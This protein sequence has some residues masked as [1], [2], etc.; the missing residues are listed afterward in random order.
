MNEYLPLATL[1]R[2]L[3][4]LTLT[5]APHVGHLPPWVS[6]LIAGLIVWRGLTAYRQWRMPGTMVKIALALLAFVGVLVHFDGRLG[7]Q[8]AGT[9]LLCVM[10][11]LKLLE[12]K[13]RRDVMVLIFLMYFMLLTHFLFSQEMWTVAYLF[14]CVLA[15]TAVLIECQ[16]RGA[17]SP[18]ITLR[19]GGIMVLQA[20]PLMVLLF[21]LFPRIPGPLWGLPEDSAAARSGLPDQMA[22]G[23]ISRL[24]ESD[25]V[26]FR[27]EFHGPVP[28]PSARYWRGPV[29]DHFDGRAWRDSVPTFASGLSSRLELLGEPVSYAIML[30]SQRGR[31]L[32]ALDM[33][34][35]RSLPDDAFIGR[36]GQLLARKP[37]TER[38]RYELT[39]YM[40]YRLAP[41][42]DEHAR[43]RYLRL[44]PDF[45]PRT[46]TLA[47]TLR[48]HYTDDEALVTAVLRMFHEQPFVYTLR[49]P[50]LGRHSVDEFLFD[51]RRGFC[52]HYAGAFSFLMRAAGIPARVVTGYQ[53]GQHNVFGDYYV[54]RQS[55]A[56]AWAEVWIENRGWVRVDPTAAVSPQRIEQSIEAAL[57]AAEGLPGHLAARTRLRFYLEAR[58]EWLNGR[59][60]A[61]VLSYG[62]EL[63]QRFLERLGLDDLRDTILALTVLGTS[64]LAF[65]GVLT[66]RQFA[67]EPVRDAALREWQRLTRRLARAGLPQRPGEGPRD[68]AA[69]VA[70][71]HPEWAQAIHHIT[72]LYVR[73][74]YLDDPDPAGQNALVDAVRAFKPRSARRRSW[75]RS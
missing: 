26:A 28:P 37:V 12:F 1:L 68:Y 34:A 53:G 11:A 50:P 75:I 44:P 19:K 66:L 49:P 3:A 42:L 58:W 14:V 33:P 39:S 4:V 63:Q 15:V 71:V 69:R 61:L 16:H 48:T 56:H 13:G 57:D 40:Q 31:W 60:N 6:A 72:Q 5:L 41:E 20:L 74:R 47:A 55:D 24:I 54:V 36:E 35:A 23:D 43:K 59:W 64:I 25:E 45:N 70:A 2:L 51:T 9:T 52:E 67:P 27:V 73:M 32:F 62:P 17:L 21:V 30:E 65:M 18:R 22:P 7:G 10:T 46:R 29:F 8:N 38:R